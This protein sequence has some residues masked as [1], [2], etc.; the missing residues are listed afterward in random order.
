MATTI[1]NSTTGILTT[2]D[3]TGSLTI[4]TGGTDA[5]RVDA[6]QNVIIPQSLTVSGTMGPINL[7]AG[8]TTVPPLDFGTN[9]VLTTNPVPNALES[10]GSSLYYTTQ[11]LS[12]NSGRQLLNASQVYSTPT[13]IG[14]ASGAQ[15]FTGARP[16]LTANH[17]YQ[18]NYILSF[19]KQTAGTV[20]FSFSN[21][22]TVNFIPLNAVVSVTPQG[23]TTAQASIGIYA[24]N[25]T[26]TTSAATASLTTNTGY[27]AVINGLVQVAGDTRLQLL[28]TDSAGTIA[29]NT[30]SGFII[31]DLGTATSIGNIA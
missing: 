29:A 19:K 25:A 17:L 10:D 8:T 1:N 14:V 22:N 12:A 31:T 24:N 7:T 26:T 6:S 13:P 9:S 11:S 15:Y 16:Q 28:I 21:S 30:G 5:I 18:I 4:Q 3:A 2:P 27:T 23:A 20:T